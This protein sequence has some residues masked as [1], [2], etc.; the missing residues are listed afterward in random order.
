MSIE[1]KQMVVKSDISANDEVENTE[2]S[3]DEVNCNP[4]YAE[5]IDDCMRQL[6]RIQTQ[7]RER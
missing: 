5:V 1:I 6:N 3:P 7:Y 4:A 2:L